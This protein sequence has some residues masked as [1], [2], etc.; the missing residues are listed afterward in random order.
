MK[1]FE[2]LTDESS[3][4][5]RYKQLA[6]AHHPDL[7]GCVETMKIINSQYESVLS[8]IYQRAGKSITEIDD[9]FKEDIAMRQKLNAILL[10]DDLIIEICGNWLWITGE[11][12]K[13]KDILKSSGFYW[14]SKKEA[15]YYRSEQFK[16]YGNR[17]LQSL[18]EIRYKH[19]SL[20]VK[21]S[22][23]MAIA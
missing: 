12:R 14:A 5:N 11:T 3:I 10:L 15:W 2:G 18:D 9:L 23:R 7:G 8:G 22:P 19:G 6:K 4:K 21:G 17:R 13:H 20:S 16:S 1:Y